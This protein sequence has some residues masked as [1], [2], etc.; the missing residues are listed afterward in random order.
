MQ[1]KNPRNPLIPQFKGS[2]AAKT[3]PGL[4][5]SQITTRKNKHSQVVSKNPLSSYTKKVDWLVS[6]LRHFR[7]KVLGRVYYDI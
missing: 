5:Q 1:L 7:L 2:Q 3:N 6:L 4:T